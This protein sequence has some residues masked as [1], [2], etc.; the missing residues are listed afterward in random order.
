MERTINQIINT[1]SDFVGEHLS[2]EDFECNFL[3]KNTANNRNYPLMF[4]DIGDAIFSLGEVKLTITLYFLDK[5]K[6]DKSNYVQ[7]LSDTLKHAEDFFTTF[8]NNE[9]K[10]GF[11]IDDNAT[12]FPISIPLEDGVIGYRL[13]VNI[14]I[15]YSVN[16]GNVPL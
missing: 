4:A 1:F 14:S 7:V 2:L 16:E 9:L 6:S 3:Q 12:A 11:M 15:K 13:P 5:L 10:Y 8:N